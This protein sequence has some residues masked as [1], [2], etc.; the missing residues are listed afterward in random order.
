MSK[1][2]TDWKVLKELAEISPPEY[3]DKIRI[4]NKI[5]LELLEAAWSD[6]NR[7]SVVQA[8]GCPHCGVRGCK[9]CKWTDAAAKVSGYRPEGTHS[10]VCSSIKFGG[11]THKHCW[12]VVYGRSYVEIRSPATVAQYEKA[13]AF[14][15]AHIEWANRKYWGRK[16][17]P[18]EET[19]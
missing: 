1:V 18:A 8:I 6:E 4:R 15:K 9:A 10:E 3:A 7:S 17:K 2:R 13:K 12:C 11:V 5:A 14:L 19:E 16:Y